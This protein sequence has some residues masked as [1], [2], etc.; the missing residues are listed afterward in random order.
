MRL[1]NLLKYQNNYIK[2]SQ[3]DT[4]ILYLLFTSILTKLHVTHFYSQLQD[5]IVMILVGRYF[6]K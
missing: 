3:N 4:N 1:L 6:S 5:N 2:L